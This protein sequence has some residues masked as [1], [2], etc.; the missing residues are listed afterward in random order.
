[1]ATAQQF[2]AAESQTQSSQ[3][4]SSAYLPPRSDGLE[5]Q[6]EA[7]T[8]YLEGANTLDDKQ[9]VRIWMQYNCFK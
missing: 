8:A 5:D 6:V 9:P 4:P 3:D 1:M 7:A 2:V